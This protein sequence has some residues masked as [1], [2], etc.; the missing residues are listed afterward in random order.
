MKLYTLFALAA[1]II[2][3]NACKKEL[4]ALPK[5]SKVESNTILDEGT[6][7]TSLNGVYY[8]FANASTTKVGWSSHQ[9]QPAE[10][11]GYLGYGYGFGAAEDNLNGNVTISYW[12]ECYRT[13]NAANG[14]IQGINKL[15]DN[16]FS[17]NRKKEILS[18]AKFLRAY[19]HFK[20]LCYFAEWYKPASTQGV[21][22]R[23][24]LSTISNIPKARS[25]VKESYDFILKDLSEASTEGKAENPNYYATK[26]AGMALK[27]RVLITRGQSTDYTE[28]ISL[29]NNII[30]NSPY[31]LEEKAED[32]FHSK[33]LASAEVILGLKPQA[34][35]ASDYYSK[36]AQ[37]WP[38]ASSLYVATGNLKNLYIDDPREAWMIGSDTKSDYSPGT[39]FFAKYHPE[40]TPVTVV[41][42]TD[43]AI[44]LT[45]VYLLKAEAI[46]RSGGNLAEAKA[47]V[48]LIQQK[49]G[50]TA[51]LNTSPYMAVESASTAA[52][53]L[54]EI[55]KETAKSLVAEDGIEWMALLRL[56]FE[57]VKVLKPTI[58]SQTQY[59]FPVPI[60]EFIYNPSFGEQN[61]GY[62]KN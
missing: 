5:N 1:V 16:K 30:E 25:S 23:D 14:L 60:S 43:Y 22:L 34:N 9:I 52:S 47:L 7:Q 28:V 18:E 31:V 48:H 56:P 13:L 42:E 49:A 44:R 3:L 46:V 50:I 4:G 32:I 21:L 27:M 15:A 55:Y 62:A 33:G 59:V 17:G 58:N 10:F 6:A 19:S 57:T 39:F 2:T 11:A 29:A 40:N 38:G 41:S 36:S 61:T 24:E 54:V 51:T 53:L 37:Y 35:Q 12:D 26:W 45:E 8:N 20:L